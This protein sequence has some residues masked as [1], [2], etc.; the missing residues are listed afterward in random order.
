M[1]DTIQWRP[2]DAVLITCTRSI[3]A[4]KRATL[5]GR[6]VGQI[7]GRPWWSLR[8]ESGAFTSEFEDSLTR[9]GPIEGPGGN[10]E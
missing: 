3:H 6:H 5:H 7:S 8:L 9:S 4:G 10:R 1:N 2:G